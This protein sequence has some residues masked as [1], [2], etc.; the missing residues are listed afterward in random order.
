M[1]GMRNIRRVRRQPLFRPCGV[2]AR[3]P[4]H[5]GYFLQKHYLGPLCM[6]QVETAA[7]LGIS[8]RR[9][10]EHLRGK[11]GMTADTAIRCALAF[12][13]DVSFWLALQTAWE[14]FQVW[15]AMRARH[16]RIPA[17]RLPR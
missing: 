8:R 6:T 16:E 7:I 3:T 13:P 5:P 9:L 14:S 12:G 4:Q 15:K 17:V 11:R 1:P 10:N 2:P